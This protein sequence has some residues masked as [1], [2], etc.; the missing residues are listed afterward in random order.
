MLMVNEK[1][2]PRITTSRVA[3]QVEDDVIKK[4]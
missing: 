3:N 1:E 4:G 2:E